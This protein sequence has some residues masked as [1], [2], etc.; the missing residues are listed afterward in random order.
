MTT[1]TGAPSVRDEIR[2]DLEQEGPNV[3]GSFRGRWYGVAL[4]PTGLIEGSM[5]GDDEGRDYPDG[6]DRTLVT[7]DVIGSWY[8]RIAGSTG[9]DREVVFHLEQ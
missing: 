7:E 1:A 4:L 8:G 9:T 3:K 6:T 5:A 2:F